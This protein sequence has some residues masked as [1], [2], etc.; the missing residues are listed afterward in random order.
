MALSEYDQNQLNRALADAR[1]AEAEENAFGAR[2]HYQEALRLD[3]ENREAAFFLQIYDAAELDRS[4]FDD[5]CRS[6]A[7]NLTAAAQELAGSGDAAARFAPMGRRVLQLADKYT[8]A[9]D[10]QEEHFASTVRQ[11]VQANLQRND[12][13]RQS[14]YRLLHTLE[15]AA[16]GVP[17]AEQTLTE[18]RKAQ[19]DMLEAYGDALDA[20]EFRP[21]AARLRA[22]LGS[23]E[24]GARTPATLLR[25]LDRRKFVIAAVLLG[26]SLLAFLIYN[27]TA[28]NLQIRLLRE[29]QVRR[30]AAAVLGSPVSLFRDRITGTQ[31]FAQ[32]P[33][34]VA[35]GQL[36]L[37]M[38]IYGGMYALVFLSLRYTSRQ[39]S[40]RGMILGGIYFGVN[41]L[42]LM[43][44]T[45]ACV[46]GSAT[47]DYATPGLGGLLALIVGA[48]AILWARRGAPPANLFGWV[49][50][51]HTGLVIYYLVSSLTGPVLRS[52]PAYFVP[53]LTAGLWCL[54]FDLGAAVLLFSFERKTKKR[55][56]R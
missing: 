32:L 34:G 40:H 49:M 18:A 1:A 39:N 36:L 5:A 48:G 41:I 6:A 47:L 33:N 4:G 56:A 21:E 42:T 9:L 35:V 27:I 31:T 55:G 14:C 12:R 23:A 45:P 11:D 22:L 46:S 7:D 51:A 38:L 24:T 20:K 29:L 15:T 50:L 53:Y 16:A 17:G 8:R 44:N 43:L 28:T 3:P 30:A 25:R 52:E 19:A 2:P 13:I 37:L 10:Y 26:L 54:F